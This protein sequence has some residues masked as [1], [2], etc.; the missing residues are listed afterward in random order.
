MLVSGV[1]KLAQSLA[2]LKC[3]SPDD[4]S[5]WQNSAGDVDARACFF[6]DEYVFGDDGSFQN[7]LGAETWVENWQIDAPDGSNP[8]DGSCTAP[9]AP[10]DGSADAS[11]S[12]SD[13]TITI[14]GL[15]ADIGLPKAITGHELS[16]EGVEVPDSRTYSTSN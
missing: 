12:T 4:G 3:P 13:T 1:W 11:F 2:R 6:D 7:I 15:G 5:W 16:N 8:N 14:S 9:V 10:H